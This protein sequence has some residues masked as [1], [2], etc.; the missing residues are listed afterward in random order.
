M[1]GEA[2]L[3]DALRAIL[4]AGMRIV[5]SAAPQA[6]PALAGALALSE[7]LPLADRPHDTAAGRPHIGDENVLC[8]LAGLKV[9]P[10]PAGIQYPHFPFQVALLADAVAKA[11][12]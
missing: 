11:R 5:A 8:R 7:L 4:L 1:A 12:G 10:I 2:H 9:P 3:L 6:I